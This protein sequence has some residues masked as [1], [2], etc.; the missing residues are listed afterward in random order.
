M[1]TPRS[2]MRG[3]AFGMVI[4]MVAGVS[5][6]AELYVRGD[7]SGSDTTHSGTGWADAYET[8]QKALDQVAINT[9]TVWK[10]VP[11]R[12]PSKMIPRLMARC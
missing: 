1:T 7:G 2:V 9:P 5:R 8:I 4:L 6:G 3:A 12:I 10:S 11:A